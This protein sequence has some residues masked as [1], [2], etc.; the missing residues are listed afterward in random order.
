[1]FG[2]C[3]WSHHDRAASGCPQIKGHRGIGNVCERGGGGRKRERDV[4][5]PLLPSKTTQSTKKGD[6]LH[7]L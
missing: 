1:M 5:E 3:E 7:V 4:N 2:A 6:S